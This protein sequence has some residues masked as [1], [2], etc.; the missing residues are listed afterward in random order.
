MAAAEPTTTAA[1]VLAAGAGTRFS[2]PVHKLQATVRGRTV[3]DHALAAA[4]GAGLDETYV[5]LGAADHPVPPEVTVLHNPAWRSGLATS[6]QTAVAAA[7][8]AGH[9]A[10]V[11]ALGDQPTIPVEAWRRVA[12]ARDRP[13]TFA[14][15]GERRGHPVRLHRSVWPLLPTTGD[16]GA[17]TALE[18]AGV[19]I[20]E[21]ACPGSPADVDT[22]TELDELRASLGDPER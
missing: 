16:A 8:D 5:V 19:E 11:V 20:G 1:V 2:G 3:L 9:E 7:R 18:A 14:R 6:L 13:A 10:V 15:Y 21:V 12:A 4:L 22:R 17:R